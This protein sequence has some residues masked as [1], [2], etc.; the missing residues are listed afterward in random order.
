[1]QYETNFKNENIYIITKKIGTYTQNF[2]FL[3]NFV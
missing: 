2:I 1:M 3:L